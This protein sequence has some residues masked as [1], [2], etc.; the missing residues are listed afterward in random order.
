MAEKDIE[1]VYAEDNMVF[2]FCDVTMKSARDLCIKLAELSK[3]HTTIRICIR[4]DGGN[5]FEGYAAMD[6]IRDL[7]ANG[8]IIETVVYGYCASAAVDIFLAGSKRMMGRNS[9]ILIHQL[10]V[11][12]GGTFNTL[13]ADMRNN[14]KIMKHDRKVYNKYTSIPPRV[15]DRLLTEDINLSAKKCLRYGIVHELI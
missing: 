4:S 5:L 1:D 8:T 7:V 6:F 12:I 15:L 2:F 10:S 3:K 13:K 9:Y 14:E 11:D